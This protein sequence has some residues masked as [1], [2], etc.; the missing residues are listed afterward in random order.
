[1]K[2][3]S[4]ILSLSL[5][6]QLC[7]GQ[8]SLIVIGVATDSIWTFSNDT[9]FVVENLISLPLF[10]DKPAE[11]GFNEYVSKNF[12]TFNGFQ[13]SAFVEF[14]IE[15]DGTISNAKIFRSL[16]PIVDNEVL[17]VINASPKWTPATMNDETV[18]IKYIYRVTFDH[19]GFHNK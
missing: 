10:D 15:K 4:T 17:R 18:R 6:V 14:N 5:A 9:N 8:K 12:K 11:I 3:L 13:G 2:K 19:Y 1:M 16:H 7:F